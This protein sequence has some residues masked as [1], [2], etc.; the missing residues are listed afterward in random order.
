MSIHSNKSSKYLE[1]DIQLVTAYEAGDGYTRMPRVMHMHKDEIEIIYI[2]KGN[3]TQIID[4]KSYSIKAG[5]ILV[6]NSEVLHDEYSDSS[7]G[8]QVY[9]CA[10]KN[11]KLLNLPI[12]HLIKEGKEA[13]VSSG[14]QKENIEAIFQMLFQTI[15]KEQET[16][17]EISNYLAS[18]LVLKIFDLVDDTN[19]ELSKENKNIGDRIKT[20]I[21]I[22]YME[23]INLNQ[24]AEVLNISSYYLA[25]LFKKQHGISPMQYV[26]RRRIGEAQ[27]LLIHTDKD[28]M[29]I[30]I[31]VGYNNANHFNT[32]FSK[33]VG[34]SPAKYRK[35]WKK[36]N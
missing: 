19:N 4:G 11:L 9:Y 22:H 26:T 13:V 15:E 20:Y 1:Q 17:Q 14:D 35:Y 34:M 29:Q 28:I 25:H 33:V 32:V 8:M 6:Y 31:T 5:D 36:T 27:S 18:V 10:I 12:N 21:D 23:D 24:I 30:A 16:A 3:G 7:V 2:K